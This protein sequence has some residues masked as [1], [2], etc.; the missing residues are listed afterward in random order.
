MHNLNWL[1]YANHN[2]TIIFLMQWLGCNF[3][4]LAD[5]NTNIFLSSTALQIML[6][7]ITKVVLALRTKIRYMIVYNLNGLP[8]GIFYANHNFAITVFPHT[9]SSLEYFPPLNSFLVQNL[10]TNNK[11]WCDEFG[12]RLNII[13]GM[14]QKFYEWSSCPFAKMMYWLGD[15]FGKRTAWSL[16]YF[17]N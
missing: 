7:P 16:I 3:W 14:V 8:N 1:F 12:S 17:L 11:G 2:F 4:L 5:Y 6:F 9:V 13:I 15:Q 10:I